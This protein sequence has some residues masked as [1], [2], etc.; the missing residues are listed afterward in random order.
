MLAF[1][2]PANVNILPI[3]II[4]GS[5]SLI[6]YQCFPHEDVCLI[7]VLGSV[8]RNT[9]PRA[10]FPNTVPRDQGVYLVTTLKPNLGTFYR[11]KINTFPVIIISKLVCNW[12]LD[13]TY[14]PKKGVQDCTKTQKQNMR[15]MLLI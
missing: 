8:S 10:V 2:L 14:L 9:V 4:G 6:I 11:D 5:L 7:F 13:K 1:C 12:K 15:H 3:C